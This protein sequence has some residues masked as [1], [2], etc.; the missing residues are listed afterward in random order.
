MTQLF[1][2]LFILF[3]LSTPCA[4]LGQADSIETPEI[5]Y[6]EVLTWP[7]EFS[8]HV[9]FGTSFMTNSF[10]DEIDNLTISN[11]LASNIGLVWTHHYKGKTFLRMELMVMN[12]QS[13]ETMEAF[14]YLTDSGTTIAYADAEVKKNTSHL[15]LPII[16]GF[17][18][19]RFYIGAGIQ[20]GII[21]VGSGHTE[22]QEK[23]VN[24]PVP[25]RVYADFDAGIRALT[26]VRFAKHLYLEASYYHGLA[27][28]CSGNMD[29][30]GQTWKIR[31]FT[32]GIRYSFHYYKPFAV[33]GFF[34]NDN[35]FKG[36]E[37]E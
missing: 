2:S 35:I 11:G 19:E 7:E 23:S 26:G 22:N 31:Q 5:P 24:R 37:L 27:N 8:V 6:R 30:K 29:T 28:I 15:T 4:G 21:M 25:E 17:E 32:F 3:L 1:R 36:T 16:Y 9:D 12:V 13:I 14:S 33:D 34:E 20:G 10:A 18:H